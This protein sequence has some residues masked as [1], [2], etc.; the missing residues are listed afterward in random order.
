MT[1]CFYITFEVN[2]VI[3]KC[4]FCLGLCQCDRFLEFGL[5]ANH[6]HAFTAAATDRLDEYRVTDI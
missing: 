5:T 2:A 6:F 3:A 4:I 1:T